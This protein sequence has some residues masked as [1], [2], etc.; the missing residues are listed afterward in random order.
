[1]APTAAQIST[2]QDLANPSG[3]FTTGGFICKKAEFTEAEFYEYWLVNHS[4]IVIPWA[5]KHG[6]LSYRQVG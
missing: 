5:E 1:M 4:A 3:P 6:I 2:S